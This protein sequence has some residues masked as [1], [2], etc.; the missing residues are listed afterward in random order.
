MK[1]LYLISLD[2]GESYE[3]H[4]RSP[5]CIVSTEAAAKVEIARIMKW[6]ESKR[7]GVPE[8]PD[9]SWPDDNDDE[10]TRVYNVTMAR[11]TDDVDVYL[12]TLKPPHGEDGLIAM[13]RGEGGGSNAHLLSIKLPF[14][15]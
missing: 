9:L 10:S 2:N 11:W 3:D 13:V 1:S 8:Q 15:A 5:V 7:I 12:R 6:V 14:R 4:H